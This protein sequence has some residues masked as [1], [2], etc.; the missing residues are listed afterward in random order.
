MGT[1]VAA[2][3]A[4]MIGQI[5]SQAQAGH[6]PLSKATTSPTRA[7]T[8]LWRVVDTMASGMRRMT[9]MKAMFAV[10]PVPWMKAWLQSIPMSGRGVIGVS[11]TGGN[12]SCR[13]AGGR[14]P[15]GLGLGDE[16]G[17]GR[18]HDRRL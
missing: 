5:T 17:Q 2:A 1:A 15:V 14:R 9:R 16:R 7:T 12:G 18:G 13:P 4:V 6:A 8:G 3:T 11:Q 10:G